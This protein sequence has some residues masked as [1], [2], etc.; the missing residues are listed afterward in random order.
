MNASRVCSD[1]I[2]H[3]LNVAALR[4]P[5]NA[6]FVCDAGGGSSLQN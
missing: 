2:A 5:D 3:E 6:W 4:R 1:V